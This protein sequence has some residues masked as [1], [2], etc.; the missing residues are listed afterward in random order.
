MN[1]IASP[2]REG[3]GTLPQGDGDSV[4]G[5]KDVLANSRREKILRE[6]GVASSRYFS[7]SGMVRVPL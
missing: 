2:F 7:L 3:I 5:L 1:K 4:L 6:W